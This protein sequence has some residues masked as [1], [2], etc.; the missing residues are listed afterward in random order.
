MRQGCGCNTVA[1]GRGEGVGTPPAARGACVHEH[2]WPVVK[3]GLENAPM[4]HSTAH[5]GGWMW[6]VWKPTETV[7]AGVGGSS[8]G[9]W[10]VA[11]PKLYT[12]GVV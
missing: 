11:F 10:G 2:F 8:G 9:M 12:K 3:M 7:M 1:D 5:V 4:E 6:G